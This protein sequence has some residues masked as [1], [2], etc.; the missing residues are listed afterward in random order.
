MCDEWTSDYGGGVCA[1]ISEGDGGG[2]GGGRP[3]RPQPGP[4]EPGPLPVLPDELNAEVLSTGIRGHGCLYVPGLL[5]SEEATRRVSR[6]CR[7][8]PSGCV[9]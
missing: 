2:A 8:S 3:D 6:V 5:D 7:A 4:L 1:G 9:K